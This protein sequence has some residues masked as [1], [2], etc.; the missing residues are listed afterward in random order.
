LRG[1]VDKL[2]HSGDV[3]HLGCL[4]RRFP[5]PENRFRLLLGVDDYL[6]RSAVVN[7]GQ[8]DFFQHEKISVLIVFDP[9]GGAHDGN[10][11]RA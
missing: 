10:D 8:F 3:F 4:V 1:S 11:I 2:V 6:G 9:D 7:I 5:G